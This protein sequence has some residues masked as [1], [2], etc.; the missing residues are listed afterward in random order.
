MPG[1]AGPGLIPGLGSAIWPGF[2]VNRFVFFFLVVIMSSF[3]CF[4]P[5]ESLAGKT[6]M[7]CDVSSGPLFSTQLN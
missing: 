7:T 6:V 4:V 5:V 3:G 2:L 1:S